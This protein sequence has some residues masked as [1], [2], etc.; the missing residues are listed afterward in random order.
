[1]RFVLSGVIAAV[2]VLALVALFV[3]ER[4]TYTNR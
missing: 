2:F 3:V 1:M 4:R